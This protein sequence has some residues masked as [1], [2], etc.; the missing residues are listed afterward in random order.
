MP[1]PHPLSAGGPNARDASS[2][3]HGDVPPLADAGQGTA[4]DDDRRHAV[5][6]VLTERVYATVTVLVVLVGLLQEASPPK[7]LLAALDV[8][9]AGVGLWLA[10]LVAERWAFRTVYRRRRRAREI[11]E[12]LIET[13]P[14][15]LAPAPAAVLL[16]LS[17]AGA[18]GTRA[19][20]QISVRLELAALAVAALTGVRRQRLTWVAGLGAVLLEVALGGAVVGLRLLAGH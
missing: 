1:V 6:A 8:G 11:R 13:G 5:A 12:L 16:L 19:A 15:V 2:G 20:L 18:L 7:P 3:S 4:A 9:L 10:R 14:L 17:A